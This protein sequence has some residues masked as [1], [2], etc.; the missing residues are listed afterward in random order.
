MVAMW[1]DNVKNELLSRGSMGRNFIVSGDPIISELFKHKLSANDTRGA[2]YDSYQL[3]KRKKLIVSS[4]LPLSQHGILS[5]EENLAEIDWYFSELSR[6][7]ANVLVSVHPRDNYEVIKTIA[8]KWGLIIMDEPL[9]MAMPACDVYVSTSSSTH[10]WAMM[11][12]TQAINTFFWGVA[13]LYEG[14]QSPILHNVSKKEDFGPKLSEI[15]NIASFA[16]RGTES[17]TSYTEGSEI[18]DGKSVERILGAILESVD[19]NISLVSNR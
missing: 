11:M 10:R 4:T 18:L 5:E 3:N 12:G 13:N 6:S 9:V 14:I 7:N 15:L 17:P 1:D 16:E 8:T 19:R 2:L